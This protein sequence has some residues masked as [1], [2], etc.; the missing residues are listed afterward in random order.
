MGELRHTYGLVNYL[1]GGEI[2]VGKLWNNK[3]VKRGAGLR[4]APLLFDKIIK[5][6]NVKKDKNVHQLSKS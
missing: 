6:V 2:W 4:P 3:M 1:Y 5:Y